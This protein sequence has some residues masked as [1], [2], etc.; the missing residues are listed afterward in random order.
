MVESSYSTQ[1][2][3]S[4][5]LHTVYYFG[6]LEILVLPYYVQMNQDGLSERSVNVL[7]WLKVLRK[8]GLD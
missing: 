3:S 1:I 7:D 8:S 6:G 4:N 5:H 2:V